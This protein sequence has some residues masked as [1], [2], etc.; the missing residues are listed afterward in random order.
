MK[1][2]VLSFLGFLVL[3]FPVSCFSG[4]RLLTFQIEVDGAIAFEGLRGVAGSMSVERMWGVLPDVCFERSNHVD[5]ASS[6]ESDVHS[7]SGQI[8]VRIVHVKNELAKS[9]LQSL[10]LQKNADGS[11]GS[12]QE[13]EA[14]RVAVH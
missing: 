10:T 1:N 7:L 9:T 11:D 3:V 8:V 14:E 12:L 6:P 4:Q 5:A 2:R 13:S